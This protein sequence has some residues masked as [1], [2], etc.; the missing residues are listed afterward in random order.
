MGSP[1]VIPLTDPRAR[2]L[3][4]LCL[5][6]CCGYFIL[7]M[8]AFLL[9]QDQLGD[10]ALRQ[11]LTQRN[12]LFGLGRNSMPLSA[13]VGLLIHA[14]MAALMSAALQRMWLRNRGLALS[15]VVLIFVAFQGALVAL[16]L[17]K[18]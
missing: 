12:S 17:G 11:I 18:I 3:Q 4:G 2:T 10:G 5:T 14:G 8:V 9:L 15:M 1:T 6:L 13:A 16:A 7:E